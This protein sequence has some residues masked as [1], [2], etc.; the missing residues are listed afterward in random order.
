M[1]RIIFILIISIF[2]CFNY[3]CT[4]NNN[5]YLF[6]KNPDETYKIVKYY[7]ND[8][9]VSIP[10]KYNGKKYLKLVPMHLQIQL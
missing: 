7:G 6:E 3:G 9:I 1:K 2:V 8:E 5:K 10:E 4:N